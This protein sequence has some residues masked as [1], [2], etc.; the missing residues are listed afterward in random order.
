MRGKMRFTM[1]LLEWFSYVPM[2]FVYRK[3]FLADG[4]ESNAGIR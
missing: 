4:F 1:V 2:L 3:S